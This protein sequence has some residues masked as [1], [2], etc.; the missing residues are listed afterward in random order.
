MWR[1]RLV[2]VRKHPKQMKSRPAA[3]GLAGI[4]FE[5]TAAVAGFSLVG[6]WIGGYFGNSALGITIGGALGVIGGTYNMIRAALSVSRR[7]SAQK[8]TID[9]K[10]DSRG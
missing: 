2:R 3:R 5:M 9:R 6:Y 10:S 1:P 7:D 4:G 8:K